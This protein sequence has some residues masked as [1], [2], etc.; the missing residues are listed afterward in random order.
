[1]I[2]AWM[3]YL[4]AIFPSH[5]EMI[6]I[7]I[8]Y[9]GRDIPALR[10]GNHQSTPGKPRKTILVSGGS[11]ARE[12]IGTST[13][14][15]LANSLINGYGQYTGIT[16]AVDEFDWVFVPTMNPDGYV[17]TWEHDRLWRKNR[18]RTALPF[19][20]GVDL[21][22]AWGFEWDGDP[23]NPCSESF[24][25]IGPF[26]GVE[27]G[28]LAD[29][30]RNETE[31]NSADFVSFLDFHSYSQQVLYPYSYSC[32]ATPPL[33]ENL[34]ELA[35]VLAKAVRQTHGHNYGVS[36]ACEGDLTAATNKGDEFFPRMR[37]GGGSALDWFYH[38]LR[39][40]Y[41]Y[42]IKLRDT[43]TYGF[44]LPKREIVP[45]GQETFN[46][47]IEL[48]RFLLS[49]KG[50]EMEMLDWPGAGAGA[51]QGQPPYN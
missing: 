8:S 43:G 37:L 30:A 31:S 49:N 21:D 42:Q 40:R 46:A 12:W 23:S 17:Y 22:R 6:N 1:V 18:Q 19:C 39:V 7:G 14:T 4:A 28:R 9:E 25:G 24:A 11:H 2:M 33:L 20:P 35:M 26:G 29:W 41:A 34:E 36:A 27:S 44:L 5:V 45:T 38:E 16:K 50:I 10:V 3:R 47:L 48:G 13:V 51:M 32:T 15:Y